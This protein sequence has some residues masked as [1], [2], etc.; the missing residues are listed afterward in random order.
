MYSVTSGDIGTEPGDAEIKIREIFE[1]ALTWKAIV[2]LDEADIFLAQR[3]TENIDRNAL[4]SVF[5][6]NLEYFDG[7]MLLTTNRVGTIDEAFQSRL[8]VALAFEP[9]DIVE[10][11][12]VWYN[13]I[14]DL[15]QQ[16]SRR[17]RE[18]LRREAASVWCYKALNGRQ[19]RNCIKT[20][21]VLAKQVCLSESDAIE[22]L[23][24]LWYSTSFTYSA[25]CAQMPSSTVSSAPNL[26]A[27][28][29]A[30]GTLLNPRL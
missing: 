3:D 14:E 6:R 4:V 1:Y 20:A 2:L 8:D 16:I 12:D 11:K 5:L 7:I 24:L 18:L 19:I 26:V 27:A 10:R 30:L 25:Q 21:S 23:R 29:W 28:R 9:L 17:E 22:K 15:S 13:F